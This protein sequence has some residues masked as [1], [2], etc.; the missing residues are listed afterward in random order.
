MHE[1][2]TESSLSRT[3][4]FFTILGLFSFGCGGGGSSNPDAGVSDAATDTLVMDAP[5]EATVDGGVVDASPDGPGL[6][7]GSTVFMPGRRVL[8]NTSASGWTSNTSF[9]LFLTVGAPPMGSA[10]G[11][12]QRFE[13][14]PFE[15]SAP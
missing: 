11:A 7:D 1:S 4:V 9:Q 10:G 3:T 13:A 8:Y 6:P 12:G 14:G 5:M 15:Q 2:A